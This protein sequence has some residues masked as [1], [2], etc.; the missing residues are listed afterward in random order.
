MRQPLLLGVLAASNIGIAFLYQWYVLVQLG[1]GVETDAL[2]AGMTLPQLALAVVSGSLMHV[3]VPLLAGEPA[4]RFRHDAWGS[5]VLVGAL[6]AAIAVLLYVFAPYW[7]PLTVPGFSDA[8]K[9]LTVH[10][11]RIQLIG[12]VFTALSGVQ[13]AV[14]HARQRFLWVELAPLLTG[15]VGL[16]PLVVFLPE[17]GVEAAAWITTLRFVFQTMLQMPG[18]GRWTIPD[19]KSSTVQ[20][21]WKRI[22]PLL[23]GTAYYK[24]DPLVDRFLLSMSGNGN[25]SL[26]YLA[27]QIYGAGAGVVSKAV[28]A[29]LVP[30]LSLLHKAGDHPAF[31]RAYRRKL[32]QVGLLTGSLLIVVGAFGDSLL[33]L[34]VGHGA[35]TEANVRTLWLIMLGLCGMFM[36]GAM[37]SVTTSSFYARGDTRLP[38]RL[39]MITY[40]IYIPI[41]IIAYSLGGVLAL[42][43]SVSAFYLLNLLLQY[44][45]LESTDRVRGG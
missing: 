27:Q 35:V 8:G 42:A 45:Y 22:Q 31:R 43:I 38:T 44:F 1:P 36:G 39:G 26:F 28:A 30:R 15:A 16:V 29:P 24:A 2:F 5:F 3:L 37:G 41:K 32:W 9:G 34:L 33:R 14:Y 12:M 18:M 40:T 21:A 23:W 6:F 20:D 11:T 10:L 17:Y 4:D 7:V 25:L 19:L 13:A